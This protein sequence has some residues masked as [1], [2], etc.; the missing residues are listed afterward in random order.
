MMHLRSAIICFNRAHIILLSLLWACIYSHSYIYTAITMR[1]GKM[2]FRFTVTETRNGIFPHQSRPEPI[3]DNDI[4]DN[5]TRTLPPFNTSICSPIHCSCTREQSQIT[6]SKMSKTMRVAS[7]IQTAIRRP[8]APIIP[9]G[10]RTSLNL[11]FLERGRK[12]GLEQGRREGFTNG[13]VFIAGAITL[14][15]GAY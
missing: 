11:N 1:G 3:V 6:T 5:S 13:V 12:A 10:R 4:P 7:S 14:L 15:S 8:R 9:R 2:A